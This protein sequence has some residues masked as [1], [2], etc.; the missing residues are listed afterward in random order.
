M[1]AERAKALLH[2][3]HDRLD[4]IVT[5]FRDDGVIGESQ[6]DNLAELSS[7]DQH[8]ADV[9]TETFNRERD[10]SVLEQVEAE[11]A[12]VE[13]ALRRVDEGSYG[14]CEACGGPI[15]EERLEAL[16]ATRFCL[17]DQATA[18]REAARPAAPDEG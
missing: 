6:E 3:E 5:S 18:E 12:D 17:A 16:P 15:A 10:L 4:G 8:P 7:A 11:L 9:A 2:A 1:D 14:T 13:R